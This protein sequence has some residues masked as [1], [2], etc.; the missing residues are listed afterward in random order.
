[1]LFYYHVK[2]IVH[3]FFPNWLANIGLSYFVATN[4]F[5]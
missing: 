5:V 4:W 3:H 2:P 1:L